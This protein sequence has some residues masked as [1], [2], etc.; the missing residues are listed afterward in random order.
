M[1]SKQKLPWKDK[2]Y[3]VAEAGVNHN[4][5]LFLAKKLIKAAK[6]AGAD[7]VKFQTWYPGELTGRFAKKID[8]L[9]KNTN[10]KQSRYYISQKLCLS[11][12]SFFTLK[13]YAKKI[14]IDF[15][16]TP[17]GEKSLDF[18]SDKLNVP[19][20]K[21]GSTELN[22]LRLLY[23]VGK[24]HKPVF[25]STGMG[26][27]KEVKAAMGTLKKAGGKKLP[28][29]VLQ[30]TTQYPCKFEEMNLKVIKTFSGLSKVEV[31]LS[32]HSIGFEASIAA[33]AL[34][35]R[36]IEKHFTDGTSF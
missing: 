13:K 35:A 1:K 21:I 15:L 14:G 25:L 22:N 36:M 19:Y 2:V 12:K 4:G 9:K 31:G 32:D 27:L 3:F 28:I 33:V 24:K 29:V 23:K 7:A 6:Y 20:I 10:I 5:K 34:G 8:Y 16:S 30:C 18:V 26:T 11:Y 17:D